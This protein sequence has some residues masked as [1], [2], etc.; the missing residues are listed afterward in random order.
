MKKIVTIIFLGLTVM[1][2]IGCSSSSQSLI[3]TD[4]E[5][6]QVM[7]LFDKLVDKSDIVGVGIAP[8]N[9]GDDIALQESEAMAIARARISNVVETK[10]I[11]SLGKYA[12]ET[13][14]KDNQDF[15]R[16]VHNATINKTKN[17][18]RGA[19]VIKRVEGKSGKIYV[20]MALKTQEVINAL[21]NSVDNIKNKEVKIQYQR[22]LSDKNLKELEKELGYDK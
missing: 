2:F 6:S 16:D 19:K 8:P 15:I 22:F 21:K 13:G 1:Q 12:R 11:N 18:I 7:N 5:Y 9:R 4:S 3:K 20:L 17:T 14:I 10:V